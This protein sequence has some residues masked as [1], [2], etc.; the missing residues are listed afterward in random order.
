MVFT[1]KVVGPSLLL[2]PDGREVP[3]KSKRARAILATLVL[4]ADWR[5]SRIWL[6]QLL[7][8][9]RQPEQASASLRQ[10]IRWLRRAFG[11]SDALLSVAGMII[12]DRTIT[13]CDPLAEIND[14]LAKKLSPPE[15][16]EGLDLRSAAFALWIEQQRSMFSGERAAT[17]PRHE[18]LARPSIRFLT[19]S[20]GSEPSR[21]LAEIF[22]DRM[23]RGIAELGPVAIV[24]GSGGS[25]QPSTRSSDVTVSTVALT[26][27]LEQAV[28]VGVTHSAT[29]HSEWAGNW[30]DRVSPE[31]PMD[32]ELFLQLIN[33]AGEAAVDAL[34]K[35]AQSHEPTHAALLGFRAREQIFSM[36]SDCALKADEDLA[37]AYDMHPQGIFQAWRAFLKANLIV[38]AEFK[39]A[40]ALREESL[41]LAARS[42]EADPGNATVKAIVAHVLLLCSPSSQIAGDLAQE[43]VSENPANP[44]AWSS[45]ANAKIQAGRL[46]EA[47]EI[48]AKALQIAKTSKFRHWWEMNSAVTAALVGDFERAR[49]HSLMASYMA[50]TFKPPLRYLT[51]LN[52]HF[53][54]EEDTTENI[55]ALRKLEPGFAPM[56]L[57][58]EAYPTGT[59]RKTGLADARKLKSF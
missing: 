3:I 25:S 31:L 49:F 11:R 19:G 26:N 30:R 47:R 37:R 17:M 9:D 15:L 18:R 29:Q 39:R 8:P 40:D 56:M 38:E 16:L 12:L 57:L 14:Q 32:K 41:Q 36:N 54:R 33:R 1:L 42:L 51:A 59:L 52:M 2:D 34:I 50:P 48:S 7:W 6:Q 22:N 20:E 46:S 24:G 35:Q 4:S 43:S 21:L 53:G 27:E 44:L 23:A 55:S 58:D 5:R 28:R 10:E 13:R 45:M